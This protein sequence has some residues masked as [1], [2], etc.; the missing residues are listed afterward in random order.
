MTQNILIL[1]GA[2]PEHNRDW[3]NNLVA[4]LKTQDPTSS[5]HIFQYEHW[6]DAS[7]SPSD[8]VETEKLANY[9]VNNPNPKVI[10]KSFGTAVA[11]RS[12]PKTKNLI[13]SLLL[14]GF[15]VNT[16]K[17]DSKLEFATF[18]KPT[19]FPILFT[20]Q[21]LDKYVH[22]VIVSEFVQYLNQPNITFR[23]IAGSDHRYDDFA[24]FI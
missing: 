24:S 20:Q 10:A 1:P 11:L 22:G 19:S 23:Q 8:E 9:L 5:V 7:L 6:L 15:P 4:Y 13:S 21:E 18:L 12:L 14:L 3:A 16:S 17:E 2:N